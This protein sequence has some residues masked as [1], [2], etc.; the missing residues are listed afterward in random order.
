M[1]V[2]VVFFD[3]SAHTPAFRKARKVD[4]INR[5][6]RAIGRAMGVDIDHP[7]ER[8]FLGEGSYD[9]ATSKKKGQ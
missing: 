4:G 7:G 8:I 3:Q 2:L 1:F 9:S 5:A 6:R